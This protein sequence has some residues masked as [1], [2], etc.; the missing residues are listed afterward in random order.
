[1]TVLEHI[2]RLTHTLSPKQRAELAEYLEKPN[3]QSTPKKPVSLRGIWKDK[4]PDDV[5]IEKV[6][7]DIRD[8][9]KEELDLYT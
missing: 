1:M 2:K 9:W 7:R 4:F 6:I 5:D 8:E 3:G